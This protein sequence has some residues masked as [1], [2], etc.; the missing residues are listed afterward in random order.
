MP[1]VVE[2]GVVLVEQARDLLLGLS[3][4]P[5][6]FALVGAGVGDDAGVKRSGAA[7][8]TSRSIRR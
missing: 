8:S 5:P 6:E 1:N 7:L 2:A 3:V 4:V